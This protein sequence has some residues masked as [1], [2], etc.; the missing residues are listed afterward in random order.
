MKRCPQCRRDYF[1]DS[2]SY[3]LDDGTPL[4][5]GPSSGSADEPATAMMPASGLPSGSS[6]TISTSMNTRAPSRSIAVLPFAHLSN[7]PDDEFFCDGLAEELLNALAKIDG[8]KVAARTSSFTFKGKNANVS[9]IGQALGVASVLEGS[10]RKSSS[11]LRITVQLISAADGYHIWSERYDREM[12]DIFEV[13]DEITLAVIEALKL[14]LLGEQRVALVKRA[15]DNAEAYELYLRG[16]AVWSNRRHADFHKAA[17]YFKKAIELDQNY[18]LAYSGLADCYSFLS[19]F[20]AYPPAE[21]R[22]LAK[23]AVSTAIELDGSLAECHSSLAMYKVFFDLDGR[24]GESEL[25][26]AIAINPNSSPAHYWYCSLLSAQG[27]DDEAIREGRTALEID[28]L[29]PVVNACMARAL[30]WAGQYEQAIALSVKNLELFP[31]F[32]FSQWVVGCSYEREGELDKAIEYYRKAIV[33]GGFVYGYLGK[34]LIRA[35]R[36]DEARAILDQLDEQSR[37]RYVSP[38]PSAVI[39]AELGDME[40]GLGLLEQAWQ[41]RVSHLMWAGVEPLFD[42]FRPEPRFQAIWQQMRI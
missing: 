34:A 7:D 4:L 17:E 14:Q 39:N 22:P 41:L 18:A 10:V 1:D 3:C 12:R 11:R 2:L 24:G 28:P 33:G 9:D 27:R 20:E 6:P 13:Q 15:T 29:S 32:F 35:G 21:M 19:Y 40:T 31:D 30:C 8:L 38:V 37:D 36:R 16:R 42:I 23:A 5:E 26:K 25:Q